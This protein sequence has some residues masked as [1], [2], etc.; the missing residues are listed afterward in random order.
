MPYFFS[1]R[2]TQPAVVPS[3]RRLVAV[4]KRKPHVRKLRFPRY[5]SRPI[6][7]RGGVRSANP[8]MYKKGAKLAQNLTNL[9]I[10]EKKLHYH[11]P[12]D[13]LTNMTYKMSHAIR[14]ANYILGQSGIAG[15]DNFTLDVF[16]GL[17]QGASAQQVQGDYVMVK[18]ISGKLKIAIPPVSYTNDNTG[19]DVKKFQPRRFRVLLVQPKLREQAPGQAFSTDDSLFI[20]RIGREWG[21]T[22]TDTTTYPGTSYTKTQEELMTGLVNK[23]KWIVLKDQSFLLDNPWVQQ[24]YSSA[25]AHYVGGHGVT[26][27][28]GSMDNFIVTNSSG[29]NVGAYANFP[30]FHRQGKYPSSKTININIPCNKKVKMN[31]VGGT[32]NPENLPALA[33]RLIIIS[34]YVFENR[35]VN[36]TINNATPVNEVATSIQYSGQ[37]SFL[38]A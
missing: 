35:A 23:Q 21:V 32:L 10:I 24:Y 36:E 11:T 27:P 14:Y 33:T 16:N 3:G 19:N 30:S 20:D 1:R 2:A 22:T 6:R 15:E 18:N 17:A 7:Y 26:L 12:Q 13:V 4:R 38:D 34:D 5:S 9:G 8:S 31:D 29:L 37:T 28:L 25:G